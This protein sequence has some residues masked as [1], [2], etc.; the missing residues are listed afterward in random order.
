M[1]CGI[2]RHSTNRPG[3]YLNDQCTLNPVWVTVDEDHFCGQFSQ[4]GRYDYAGAAERYETE[5][6]HEQ[7]KRIDTERRLKAANAKIKAM[8]SN[9]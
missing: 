6:N 7:R 9:S 2:C 1:K 8:R 3:S 4:H 5:A